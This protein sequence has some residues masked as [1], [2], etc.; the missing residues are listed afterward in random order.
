MEASGLNPP[1]WSDGDM[2]APV[3]LD[4]PDEYDLYGSYSQ[5]QGEGSSMG[6]DYG[7]AGED[8][9][10]DGDDDGYYAEDGMDGQNSYADHFEHQQQQQQQQMQQQHGAKLREP[11][12]ISPSSAHLDGS[13]QQARTVNLIRTTST[14]DYLHE[15]YY[16]HLLLS[17]SPV[18]RCSLLCSCS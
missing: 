14:F 9:Y 7:V 16:I 10:D 8:G 5:K 3:D 1:E 4:A 2:Q 6:R 18:H 13:S 15:R 17:L 12:S 11:F